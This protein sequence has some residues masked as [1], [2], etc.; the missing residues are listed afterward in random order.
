MPYYSGNIGKEGIISYVEQEPV[1]FSTSVKEN[2]LFGS[3][4]DSECY[5][6]ALRDSCLL[7]DLELL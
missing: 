6:N 2:V 4:L 7:T 5:S 3:P 1:L